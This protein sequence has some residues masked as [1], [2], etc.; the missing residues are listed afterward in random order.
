MNILAEATLNLGNSSGLIH[1]LFAVLIIGICC[2]IIWAVGRWFITKI[3]QNALA[4]TV[5]NGFFILVGCIIIINFLMS[6]VGHGFI[7]Y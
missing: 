2:A 1:S 4:M 7:E 5:W 3:T 6:L